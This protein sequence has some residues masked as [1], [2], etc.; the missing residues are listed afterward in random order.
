M[1]NHLKQ[2][3]PVIRI[4]RCHH[5]WRQ[6]LCTLALNDPLQ[7][8][9]MI[10]DRSAAFGDIRIVRG[11]LCSR[12]KPAQVLLC[13][14]QILHELTWDWT[15]ATRWKVTAWTLSRPIIHYYYNHH[16]RRR[17]HHHHH[18]HH[19]NEPYRIRLFN[20]LFLSLL[21]LVSQSLQAP[22]FLRSSNFYSSAHCDI[23]RLFIL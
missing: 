23:Q 10:V 4:G 20:C 12:I 11:N 17:R 16:H 22:E 5:T 19:H 9:Q 7:Q 14:P 15:R 3:N 8:P 18:H 13:P 21:V 1:L 6:S 2:R